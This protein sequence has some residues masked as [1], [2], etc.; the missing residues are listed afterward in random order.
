MQ[1]SDFTE[2]APGRLVHSMGGQLCFL[3]GPLPGRL[4]R[5][6][7]LG[8]VLSPAERALGCRIGV[9][10]TLSNPKVVVRSFLR[11]ACAGRSRGREQR[12]GVDLR[13]GRRS[14]PFRRT[15]PPLGPT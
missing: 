14:R 7:K 4:V 13:T 1:S 8:S 12:E 6:D 5:D 2:D 10:L 9:G 11:H 15:D 3:P